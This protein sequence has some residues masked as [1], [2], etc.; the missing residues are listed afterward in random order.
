M[1][2]V[3]CLMYVISN[4]SH[5]NVASKAKIETNIYSDKTSRC[6]HDF[7]RLEDLNCDRCS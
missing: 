2:E 7:G 5:Q 3:D 1:R 4:D 6:L